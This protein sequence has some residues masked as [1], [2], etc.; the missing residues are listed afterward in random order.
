MKRPAGEDLLS[1]FSFCLF[2]HCPFCHVPSNI[3]QLE[4]LH[5]LPFCAVNSYS[6]GCFFLN[7]LRVVSAIDK[8]K[9]L[10][11][12]IVSIA[13]FIFPRFVAKRTCPWNRIFNCVHSRPFHILHTFIT[14]LIRIQ[15]KKKKTQKMFNWFNISCVLVQ[16]YWSI[17]YLAISYVGYNECFVK[18]QKKKTKKNG[19]NRKTALTRCFLRH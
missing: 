3:L 19:V 8:R 13:D 9:V 6:S 7:R 4:S 17:L 5:L 16:K 11:L 14:S 12:R 1:R 2:A 10:Q 15:W 18:K